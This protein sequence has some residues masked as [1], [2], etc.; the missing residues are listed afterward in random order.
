LVEQT[1][2]LAPVSQRRI[3]HSTSGFFDGRST[4]LVALV[5][6]AFIAMVGVLDYLTGPQLS[7]SLL[8]L[9]PIGLVTW[10]MGRRWGAF[11][12]VVATSMGIVADIFTDAS[13]GPL[14]PVPYWNAVVRFAVFLAFA[15]LLDTLRSIIDTQLIRVEKETGVSHGLRTLNDAKDTL[16]HAVSHDLKSPLA[17]ILGAMQTIRRDD[18]LHLSFGER[19]SLYAVIEQSGRKMN[20]LIDDLLD[21][22]RIDRGKLSPR[23]KPTD[24][25]ELARRVARESTG[26]T[27]HPIRV[28]ADPVVVEVDPAK[29]ER[30]IDNLLI[31]A[32]RHTP[33][34][35]PIHVL[36]HE[37]PKGVQLIVEDSGPGVPDDL[38]EVLFEP[39]RQG[40]TSSG[41]GVGI[42]LSL[43]KSFAELHGGSAHIEDRDGGGARFVIDLPGAV[44]AIAEPKTDEAGEPT[45]RAV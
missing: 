42:G 45:L 44:T 32:G 43:V 5:G 17:G 13:V 30:V 34:G 14:N 10:N 16:L 33:A 2:D 36:V 15:V 18:E 27:S 6:L 12:V 11:A 7:L 9:M 38:K 24:V 4:L 40:Q 37:R 26:L 8:Y 19:E 41:R 31:N 21:L 29:V 22:D 35:T 1:S 39:F 25:G 3:V 20:R 28:E 23:R